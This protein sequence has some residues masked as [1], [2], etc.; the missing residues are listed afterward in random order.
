MASRYDDELWELVPEFGAGPPAHLVAFVHS[1]GQAERALDL[2][3][4]DGRLTAELDALKLF[5]ADVSSVALDRARHRLSGDDIQLI[6]LEPDADLPLEDSQ[7][8]LVLCAETLE[9]VRDVQ[10]LLSEIRRVLRPGGTLAVTTPANSRLTGLKILISGFENGFNPL[11]PHVRFFSKRSLVRL[12][13]EMGYDVR[14]IRREKGTLLA[15][16]RR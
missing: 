9:H 3:C 1:L 8:D 10:L 11:S 6:E 16:A 12:L 2:G 15:T 14:S 7:F 4:G 13:A 5:A